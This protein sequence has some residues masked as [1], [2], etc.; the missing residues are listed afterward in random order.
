[1]KDILPGGH[2]FMINLLVSSLMADQGLE[3]ALITAIAYEVKDPSAILK[4]DRESSVHLLDLVRQLLGNASSTQT[5][6]LKHVSNTRVKFVIKYKFIS[7]D[8]DHQKG[9]CGSVER[10]YIIMSIK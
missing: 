6:S 8:I 5:A 2:Q 9:Y 1:M 7:W 10:M 3:N 4:K